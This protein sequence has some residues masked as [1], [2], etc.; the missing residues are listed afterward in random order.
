[1]IFT[2]FY[3]IEVINLCN[4]CISA[5]NFITDS[6]NINV[7]HMDCHR[8]V[9]HYYTIEVPMFHFGKIAYKYKMRRGLIHFYPT[10]VADIQ[11]VRRGV[12]EGYL[13]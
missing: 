5:E 7:I 6:A 12:E 3:S 13:K 4:S 11:G 2:L 10:V 1:M 8:S 9:Q